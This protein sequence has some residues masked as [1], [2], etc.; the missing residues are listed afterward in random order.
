MKNIIL[1]LALMLTFTANMAKADD[2]SDG[3]EALFVGDYATA[4]KLWKPLAESGH[5]EAQA[6]IGA[7]Y[8]DGY[9]V[10]QDDK[11]AAKWFRSSAEQG[12]AGA[13]Y[14]LGVM[15]SNG[16][17]VLQDYKE[18]VK[19]YRKAAEQGD[20][21]AQLNLGYMYRNGYGLLQ[22]HKRAHMWYN[23]ARS[24][25]EKEHAGENIEIISRIMPPSD[26]SKAQDMARKCVDSGY[27]DC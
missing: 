15:Y 9:G 10:I 12:Y 20:A 2:F 25:G 27:Q 6:L 23:I 1:M 24:N 13:Q 3:L 5:A 8:L 21:S 11:E 7:M 14:N 18:A 17:G 22:D 4:L 19:W 16:E 26:I